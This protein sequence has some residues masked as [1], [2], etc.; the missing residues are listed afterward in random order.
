[1]KK[2]ITVISAACLLCGCVSQVHS[3][4]LTLNNKLGAVKVGGTITSVAT[5]IINSHYVTP[6]TLVRVDAEDTVLGPWY[7]YTLVYSNNVVPILQATN[8][9]QFFRAVVLET[10]VQLQWTN[11]P[12]PTITS[13][14]IYGGTQSN[15]YTQ[16]WNVGNTNIAN[17]VLTNPPP[18]M[19][20]AVVGQNCV[21]PAPLSNEVQYQTIPPTLIM[22]AIPQPSQ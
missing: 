20:F 4:K 10:T 5:L 15:M 6:Y 17:I 1:M 2:L 22:Q 11:P 8:D 12:D 3:P 7:Q 18:T 21:G 9:M 14:T 16:N 13:Y 19:Y